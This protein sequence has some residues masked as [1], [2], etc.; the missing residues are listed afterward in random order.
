MMS[1][2]AVK[3]L[4]PKKTVQQAPPVD[5]RKRRIGALAPYK[6]ILAAFIKLYITFKLSVLRTFTSGT[7]LLLQILSLALQFSILQ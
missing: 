4:S 5:G 3:H 1:D 7:T 2:H 6:K